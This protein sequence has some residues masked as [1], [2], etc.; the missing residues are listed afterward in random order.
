[1]FGRKAVIIKADMSEEMQQD[2]VDC[3]KHALKKYKDKKVCQYTEIMCFV[4][5]L[6]GWF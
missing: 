1:M 3:A 4:R 2:A 5:W 6:V